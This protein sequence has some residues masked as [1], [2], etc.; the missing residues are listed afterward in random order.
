[1]PKL[2]LTFAILVCGLFINAQQMTISVSRNTFTFKCRADGSTG[3]DWTS[4]PVNLFPF[5][6]IGDTT[7]KGASSTNVLGAW[8][9]TAM[10]NNGSGNFSASVDLST[11]FSAGTKVNNIK[12][13]YNISNGSGGFYQNPA[14]GGFSATDAAHATGYTPVTISTLAVGELVNC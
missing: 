9:G 8:P 12:F 14:T 13:I 4:S 1:M 5:T 11:L 3:T 10:V 6:D 7:P 2:L